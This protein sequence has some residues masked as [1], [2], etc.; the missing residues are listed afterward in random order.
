MLYSEYVSEIGHFDTVD[1]LKKD[2][3]DDPKTYDTPQSHN[4]NLTTKFRLCG[5]H[6]NIGYIRMAAGMVTW[7][8]KRPVIRPTSVCD[9]YDRR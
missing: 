4:N 8:K 2:S 1:I 9:A 5:F 7:A 3:T 6:V